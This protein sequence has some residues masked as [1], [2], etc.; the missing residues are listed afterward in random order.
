[1]MPYSFNPA[2]LSRRS[3]SSILQGFTKCTGVAVYD[4]QRHVIGEHLTNEIFIV[5]IRHFVTVICICIKYEQE[6]TAVEEK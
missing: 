3:L 1:M 5:Y 6:R 2:Y 4:S